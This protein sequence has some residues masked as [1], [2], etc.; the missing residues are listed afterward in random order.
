ME[1]KVKDLMIKVIPPEQAKKP[2]QCPNECSWQ[3]SWCIHIT[4]ECSVR[5]VLCGGG[6]CTLSRSIGPEE[7]EQPRR[8]CVDTQMG[9]A[10][11][12]QQSLES[13]AALRA[14]LQQQ[15]AQ[16][17]AQEKVVH[18]SLAP[19]SLEDAEAL[20]KKLSEALEE[21]RSMK[22]KFKKEAK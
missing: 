16:V 7:L 21:V 22:E 3:S 17:N 19:A 20:E 6:G 5:S 10:L 8:W 2:G 4:C 11:S 15:L 18:E 13:L 12:P 1:F 14:Q 9:M